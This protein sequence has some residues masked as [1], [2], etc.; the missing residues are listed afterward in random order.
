MYVASVDEL[1]CILK[2]NK[3]SNTVKLV[4][5]ALYCYLTNNGECKYAMHVEF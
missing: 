3:V 4:D 2:W 5:R 1:K